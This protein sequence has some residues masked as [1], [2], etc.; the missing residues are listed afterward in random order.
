MAPQLTIFGDSEHHN[1]ADMFNNFR[2]I[3]TVMLL[4]I[5]LIVA[6]GKCKYNFYSLM[7][8]AILRCIHIIHIHIT[9]NKHT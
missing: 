5:A 8:M 4:I 2:L 6:I 7:M 1:E 9:V 3:G